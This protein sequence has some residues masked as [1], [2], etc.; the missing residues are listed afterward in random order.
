[1]APLV[2]IC[3]PNLNTRPFL[4]ERFATIEGQTLADWELLVYDSCST[5]GAWEYIAQVARREPR[6]RAWQGPREGTPASWNPCIRE[7]RGKYVYIATSDDT[8]APNCLERLVA[9]LEAHPECDLA[10]CPLRPIDEAGRERADLAAWWRHGSAFAAASGA[11][12][13]RPHVRRP[14]HDGLLHLL[15]ASVYISITQLLIRRSLFD[16]IGGFESQWGSV[17]DFNWA[18]RA[19]LVSGTVH[20]P[21]TWG[22]WRLHPAQATAFTSM[23]SPEHLAR[24]D[25]MIA[26]AVESS[27]RQLAPIVRVQL[28]AHWVR[29]AS[30]F[31]EYAR[32]AAR[33]RG[34]FD[35]ARLLATDLWAGAEPVREHIALRLRGRPMH[36]WAAR[37]LEQIGFPPTIVA[38]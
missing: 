24:V 31:R 34:R 11:W 2:S 13:D 5:D 18:M 23:G 17:G 27:R 22:G 12:L 30:E 36:H 8:M 32:R 25:S 15:G 29:Q 7:A 16:R 1:M 37:Q 19:G 20:V 33:C 14:P 35:F 28:S 26:H 4:P 10:H 21:D 3:V 6:V 38:A 9:A